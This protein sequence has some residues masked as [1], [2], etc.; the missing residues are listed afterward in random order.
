MPQ[1]DVFSIIGYWNAKVE[2]Q[3]IPGVTGNISFG[4]QNEAGQRL[5]EFCGENTLI[6]SNTLFEQHKR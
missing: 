1:K 4:V 3:E 6:I 5:A 2:S